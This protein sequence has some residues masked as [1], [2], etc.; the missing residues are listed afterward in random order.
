MGL[1]AHKGLT[2]IKQGDVSYNCITSWLA[3]HTDT[4]ACEAAMLTTPGSSICGE[5]P[6][7]L[8]KGGT[9]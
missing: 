1:D 3:G 5:S 6:S 8:F 9:P 7:M 2:V 4:T